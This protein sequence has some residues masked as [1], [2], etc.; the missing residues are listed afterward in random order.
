MATM[1][2][3]TTILLL[4]IGAFMSSNTFAQDWELDKNK[5]GIAI[6]TRFEQNS[7]FKSFKAKTLVGAT[8]ADIIEILKNADDYVEWYGFTKTS[9]LLER[10]EG[11][12]Y[13]YVETIF[14]WPFSN[15]DMVY[16]MSID[17]IEP[18]MIKIFLEGLPDYIEDKKGI[19]RMKL[20]K[21]YIQLQRLDDQTA[22]TYVFHSDPGDHI[23][24]G[25]A[26][27]SIAELP[28]KTLIGLRKR[29]EEKNN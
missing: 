9:R 28:F 23:P 16:K 19:V 22:I 13:N 20:A 29:L 26:N 10:N 14:P 5:D 25:L 2:K 7:A 18:G 8:T 15:R 27:H 11:V 12:Q 21:G 24:P 17:S 3:T 4:S 1:H 6:Y